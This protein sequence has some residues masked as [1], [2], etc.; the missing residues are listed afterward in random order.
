MFIVADLVSLIWFIYYG[1]QFIC[2]VLRGGGGSFENK[3]SSSCIKKAYIEEI[4][5]T[6]YHPMGNDMVEPC[7]QTSKH[8]RCNDTYTEAG[9]ECIML[10]CKKS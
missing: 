6:P 2:T 7:N 10:H 3:S 1:S 4:W 9:L 5:N 8:A